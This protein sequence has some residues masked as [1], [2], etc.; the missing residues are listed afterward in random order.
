MTSTCFTCEQSPLS[1]PASVDLKELHMCTLCAITIVAPNPGS[2][3]VTSRNSGT[4]VGDGVSI[5]EHSAIM[6]YYK[7]QQYAIEEAIFHTPGLHIFPGQ[8]KVYPAEYHIH[9]KAVSDPIRY[10]T[11]LIPVSHLVPHSSATEAYFATMKK[12]RDPSKQNPTLE[13]LVNAI[14]SDV[15]QY[16]GADI[17]G[18]VYANRDMSGCDLT[19][20]QFFMVTKPAYIKASDLERI[21]RE[22]SVFINNVYL[23][24]LPVRGAEPQKNL[25]RDDIMR[26]VV[27]AKPGFKKKNAKD[28]IE[29]FENIRPIAKLAKD[30]SGNP[31]R[32]V[33]GRE[34]VDVSGGSVSL[35]DLV[36]N[37]NRG[38]PEPGANDAEMYRMFAA[39][40]LFIRSIC[41]II[42][43]WMITMF[44]WPMFFTVPVGAGAVLSTWN[45]YKW[46]LFATLCIGPLFYPIEDMIT[47]LIRTLVNGTTAL[48][49]RM[50]PLGGIIYDRIIIPYIAPIVQRKLD[51]I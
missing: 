20:R 47:D 24:P 6:A 4:G 42:A 13:S 5:R 26:K 10:I 40:S 30:A 43:D 21:P 1:W 2:L 29:S 12:T 16:L 37:L 9:M 51:T 38:T 19:E 25:L 49:N 18:R 14:D 48:I 28:T 23:P 44:V 34:I 33:R 22:G 36:A 45:I 31:L 8:T 46:L 17:R 41:F 11:L 3:E 32:L 39:L 50:G 35:N 15:V 27:L 7:H